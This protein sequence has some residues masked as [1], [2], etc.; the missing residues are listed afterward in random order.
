MEYNDFI[1]NKLHKVVDSGFTPKSL[2]ENLFPF[3]RHI[4]KR[5]LKA[6]CFAIF[7]DCGMGKTLMQLAFA[8]AIVKETGNDVLI[9]APLAVAGQTIQ[10][11]SRFGI[12]VGRVGSKSQI[13][14]TNYEQ[15][16]NLDVSNYEGVILDESSIL[17][18]FTGKLKKLIISSFKNTPY[19]LACT[20][21]PSPNDHNELGNHSEFLGVLDAQDMRA[22][23][24]VRDEGMNNYRLKG[25]AGSD[26]F[27]WVSGWAVMCSKPSDVGQ[28]SDKGYCLP[29]LNYVNHEVKTG[30]R[31][32]GKLFNDVAV[33]ATN[34]N[35][36][37]KATIT[38]RLKLAADVA[39][40]TDQPVIVW[41]NR[42]DEGAMACKLIPDAVEVTGS[43]KPEIKEKKLLGFAKGD[44]RVLVTKKKIAQFGLNYQHCN[45][46]VFA[47]LD[48]SFEALYQS[49]RRSYRFGQK[50]D[51]TIHIVTTDTM[52]NVV[53]SIE[54]KER[55]FLD[56]RDKMN[57]QIKEIKYGLKMDYSGKKVQTDNYTIYNMDCVKGVSMMDDNSVDFSVFS[58][59]FSTLFT[60]SNNIHDMGNC[61][62]DSEFFEQNQYLLNEL[63]RVIKP[64]RLVAVHSKDLPVYKGSSG[65]TGLKDFTGDYHR[66][67]EKAGFKYHSKI[68]IWTDPV[69]ERARTNTQRLLYHQ[70]RK[71]ASYSGVGLPEYITVFRKWEG[72]REDWT[73]IN[74]KTKGNFPLSV[75]Q[76]WA[77]S[78]WGADLTPVEVEGLRARFSDVIEV[79]GEER[80]LNDVNPSWLLNSWFD[81]LRT[82][83]LNDYRRAR[84]EKDEKH[85]APLQTTV[86]ERCVGMWSNPG[87]LVLSPF[88]G[89]GSE[90]YQSILMH[91]KFIGFEL[92]EAYFN[93]A[94]RN[95]NNAC[96]KSQQLSL[97]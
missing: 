65:Y 8:D 69:L 92:K 50:N 15:L 94:V 31:N 54:R 41:V 80:L 52:E 70:V 21:T 93:Q 82:D 48:F 56:M 67:M 79:I 5:A 39:N 23:W 55:N 22:R 25:H 11:G 13:Q 63:Y 59:P 27:S 85:I 71:D 88:A 73:P 42:N 51:V 6:G 43:E 97:F 1:K 36:E 38:E 28:Y 58:P 86:I 60:Y 45:T 12:E 53:K 10:E 83:V 68:T 7:A 44:F 95:L 49:I 57:K 3:Q 91:R 90:G 96:A 40:N 24:F 9:L 14:I 2:N 89:I 18:N 61:V 34:F 76:K 32:N 72:D 4:V 66:A 77:S 62:N 26:F 30:G 78:I 84:Q 29:S 19:K 33:S 75:W 16:K 46:Q 47:S 37:L 81:I 20:A 17:K 35:K 64:G 87:E 74:N